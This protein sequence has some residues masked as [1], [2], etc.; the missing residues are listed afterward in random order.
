[1][2]DR[3][4]KLFSP[5]KPDTAESRPARNPEAEGR[6]DVMEA[7]KQGEPL[8]RQLVA[9]GDPRAWRLLSP[10]LTYYERTGELAEA[11]QRLAATT[12]QEQLTALAHDASRLTEEGRLDA[13]CFQEALVTRFPGDPVE[14]ERCA[15]ALTDVGRFDDAMT[16]FR[17]AIRLG[18]PKPYFF[19]WPML[20][21]EDLTAA[22]RYDDAEELL[23]NY[24]DESYAISALALMLQ[25]RGR[26]AEAEE[27]LRPR[28]DEAL[29]SHMV[30][31]QE[32]LRLTLFTLLERD[33]R[34]D[35]AALLRPEHGWRH[36]WGR[37]EPANSWTDPWQTPEQKRHHT[38]WSVVHE[39]SRGTA[40]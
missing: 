12:S 7:E 10:L 22:G 28:I 36:Q 33:G 5:E 18:N 30:T 37:S 9:Q 29:P 27:L 26:T 38:I 11:R 24:P 15:R 31:H 23:R 8:L 32:V 6:W 2:L 3:L 20:T 34:L 19:R 13:A 14:L 16:R 1:M 35:E 17:E 40:V 25:V 39:W 21:I 4:K